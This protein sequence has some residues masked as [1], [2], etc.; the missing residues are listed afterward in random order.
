MLSA[1]CAGAVAVTD[2]PQFGQNLASIFFF[3]P[4]NENKIV[5]E[6]RNIF[7][8]VNFLQKKRLVNDQPLQFS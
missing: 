1:V 2:W 6:I 4:Q 8:I 5:D 7:L 3:V